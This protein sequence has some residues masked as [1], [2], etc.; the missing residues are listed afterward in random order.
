MP[1]KRFSIPAVAGLV[2]LFA[3]SAWSANYEVLYHFASSRSYYP[4]SGLVVD[5]AGNAYGTTSGHNGYGGTVYELSPT[6][7][8][9]V[10][11]AFKDPGPSGWDPR[12]NLIFDSAGNLYGT[13]ASG[14]SCTSTFCGVVFELSPPS[15]GSPGPWTETVLHTFCSQTNCA[16]GLLPQAGV[17][18]DS[19]GNLYG[20]T[21]N[22]GPGACEDG[23]GVVFELTPGQ[24]GQWT[25]SVLYSFMNNGDG[26][27]PTGN[28][29][30][31]GA[32][33]L[34]GTTSVGS[35][36]Q[37]VPAGAGWTFNLLYAFNRSE[38]S[39]DGNDP[40]AGLVFDAAGNLYGTTAGGG[41]FGLG[42]VF[43]LT[44]SLEGS[45]TE[46]ILHN[47]AGGND[48]SQPES[49][50]I[51]DPSGNLDGTTFT[52]GGSNGCE[53]YT[54]GTV[55]QLIPGAGGLWTESIFR[56]P[57]NGNGGFGPTA[58]LLIYA[59]SAYGT[60]TTGGP[61][62]KSYRLGVVFKLTP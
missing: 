48:G 29:I 24:G 34:Y 40:Q 9:H 33:N 1:R 23:C 44:P 16:D 38:G 30:F 28:L 21:M 53:G 43:E 2:L 4:S 13:A 54:C 37:L 25:E 22:G 55:F 56:F 19:A 20:T 14:G 11:Y 47:F 46:T 27:L 15:S 50:L 42:T 39:K 62:Q 49:S 6:T 8:F 45:W 41:E 3:A 12:G 26:G 35:V 59:G 18:M 60:T 17:I 7:G 61:F 36:F 32:G 31:D 57:Q 52:G 5:A 51:F 10:L 58:P